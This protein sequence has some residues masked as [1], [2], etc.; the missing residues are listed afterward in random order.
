MLRPKIA[1]VTTG[2]EMQQTLPEEIRR[3]LLT[4]IATVPH[5]EA[6]LLLWREPG[7]AWSADTIAARLHVSTPSA[8][9]IA[10]D[11]CEADFLECEANIYRCRSEPSLA[12]LFAAVDAAYA[13][14]LREMTLLIHSNTS[15]AAARLEPTGSSDEQ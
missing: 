12:R 11:L 3:F 5:L 6:L 14:Q 9:K 4:S 13:R 15:R 2:L 7:Q 8:E 10:E 1:V